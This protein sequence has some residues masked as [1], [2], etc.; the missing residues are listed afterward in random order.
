MA[1]IIKLLKV[2]AYL[3]GGLCRGIEIIMSWERDIKAWERDFMSWA[4]DLMSWE[5]DLMSWERDDY[6]VGT[7]S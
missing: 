3:I 5:R 4:R 2:L 1:S 6:V 7:R